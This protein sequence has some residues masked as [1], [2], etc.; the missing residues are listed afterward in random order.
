[1]LQSAVYFMT[2]KNNNVLYIGVGYFGL[3]CATHFGVIVPVVPVQTVPL[4]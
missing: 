2:N 4:L 1:M 3:I